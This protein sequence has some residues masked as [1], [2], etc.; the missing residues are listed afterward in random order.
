L[1]KSIIKVKLLLSLPCE[2]LYRLLK[3]T[4]MKHLH[5]Y[6]K[7]NF[8]LGFLL[9]FVFQINIKA[10][11]NFTTSSL[12]GA[13][14][15]NPTSLQFGPDNRLYVSQQNGIIKVFTVV[16]NSIN[17]YSVTATET[18]S[19]INQIPNHNDDGT[20]NTSVT[21]RQVTGILVTGT[22]SQPII[23]VTSSD[24]RIGGGSSG[25]DTNLD[26]N[27]G[28]LSILTWNGSTWVKMDLVRGLPRSEENHSPN[29]MQL[30]P[31]TNTLYMAVGGITNAGSPSN[32]FG[33]TCEY[34]L[35]AAILSI[36]L[37]AINAM[38]TKGSGNTAYKYDLPTVDDPTRTN[39]GSAD[40][41]DPFGGNDGLNQAKIV[42]G[43]PVKIFSPGYR[44][45]YDL[46]I[47]KTPGKVGRIYTI[48]NGAN[49]G[50]GGYPENEGTP[51]V[52]NN[53]VS[54]E[55]GSTGPSSTE[56]QVNNLD[57][58]H[59][60]GTLGSYIPGSYYGG[61]PVPIRANPSGA[62]LYTRTGT[63]GVFRTSTSGSNPLPSDW[64][65]VPSANPIEGDFQMP[66]TSA[67]NA[68]LT[69]TSST[70]GL[71][72]Y[73]AS[74]FN[75]ALK[76]CLLAAGY[77]GAIYKIS[78]TADGT[79]ATNSKSS[80]NKVNQD[81]P[82]ASGFGSTPLDV[83]AQG[84]ND[85]FPGTVWAATYGASAITI[86]EPADMGTC[87]GLYNSSDDDA[88]GYTNADEMDNGT[89]PCSA[90]SKPNDF[91]HDFISDLNDPDDD[92]DGIA[93]SVD[94]FPIDAN[95]GLTT[96][97]PI[98]YDLLN[99]Y[100][101]TGFFGV[102]FTGLMSNKQAGNNYLN[103]FDPNNL[104]AG[105]AVG[106]FT[107]VS[108]SAKDALGTLNNQENA[109]QFGVMAGGVPFTI[110][111]RMLGPFFSNQTPSGNQSQGI[112]I[113]TGDQSNYLKIT[114]NANNGQGG[115][116]VVN[117]NADVPVTTQFSIAGGIPS[118]TLD[119]YLSVNPATGTV[120]A[121]YASNGG[122]VINVGSPIQVN[123]ALLNALKSGGV[124]AIGIIS[125]SINATP[126]T[127]TW[128][129]IY[130]TKDAVT[131]TGSWQT[132]TPAA[133]TITTREENSYGQAGTKFYLMGGRG[134]V[135][136]QEYD[137]INKTW[138]NKAS[139][140]IELNHFQA[141]TLDGLIYA[142]CAFNGPF[143]HE[144]PVPQIYIYDPVG[145]K[146]LTGSTIPLARRR[147]S[148]GAVV[149]KNKIYL[150]GGITDGHWSGWVNWFDEYDPAT[151]TWRVLPNAPRP[152]DHFHIVVLND[153]LY[154]AG[155]R[156]SSDST[157]ELFS[158][159]IPEVDVY[160]F[161][162]GQWS[163]L[164]SASNIPTQRAG[165][166]NVII[167]NEVI[168]IGG[169]NTQP[170]A[171]NKTEALNTTTNTWRTLANL[172]QGRH[173]TQAIVNN[174]GIY[175]A[176]GAG[177]QGGSNLLSTQEAFYFSTP[178]TPTGQ[179]LSQSQLS[180]VSSLN[181]GSVPV[182]TTS[183]N[184]VTISN[185]G[186]NQAILVSS[187]SLTGSTA[188]SFISPYVLPFIIAPGKSVD[189]TVTFSP[190]STGSQ[191]GSL[192][193]THSGQGG[194][195]TTSLTG[196]GGSTTSNVVYRINSGG[197]QL[198]TSIGTFAADNYFSPSPGYTFS[199][200]TAIA[201]TTDDALYQTERSSTTDNGTFSYA[202]PVSNGTY[203]VVLHFAEIYQT[204]INKRVFDVSI[205]NVKVLDNYDIYKKVGGFTA[206]TETFTTTVSDGT[207]NINFSAKK[208]DGGIYRPEVTAIE[209]LNPGAN[210]SIVRISSFINGLQA[211]NYLSTIYPNPT[212]DGR[213]KVLLPREQEGEVVYSL[214]SVSGNVL[215]KGK[216]S[217]NR[218]TTVL[219]FNF[220][221]QMQNAGMYYLKLKKNENEIVFKLLRIN[222]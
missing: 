91:D 68:I 21:T 22:A 194:S 172:Q 164:S 147:G 111:A 203:T 9:F 71:A 208:K 176:A 210:P 103:N 197:P 143:P 179:A 110:K 117:E 167:G 3:N 75:N 201:G 50:W 59:Y 149:Y 118:S 161:I 74:N 181:F 16:R 81:P 41:N 215:T 127:A 23:Y 54:G 20:L 217:L 134:I 198:N 95:N 202:F 152:R 112:F 88:D 96:N 121:K 65:P 84:D 14:L 204:A 44:N 216:L 30:D 129:Y 133:G 69:F 15:T 200:T 113:G 170:T 78:L 92:N 46:V 58:L 168:V 159:T 145:N 32:N 141:V 85:I 45:A 132:L 70:N 26:T 218:P 53:Y 205:E 4:K 82:F 43:G 93:D 80:T 114:L 101:G 100:P 192:V 122:S 102:G 10:Q 89:N 162:T 76:G 52:T 55:P 62:G 119:L 105:G 5:L 86:F 175:I 79:D 104:V 184:K 73:T 120:Q 108:V 56:A 12:S 38:T 209:V 97:M 183:S 157:G 174:D 51:N 66:G 196:Q 130:V 67:S 61:H 115:I 186:S 214:M 177:N 31:S 136:V 146:W 154:V 98:N 155:G 25:T 72:E 173:G 6:C 57:G 2:S 19:I 190:S 34:A 148:A 180:A 128:D 8:I 27:S 11:V 63:T 189:I 171:S 221:Q 64:P 99:N 33:F 165:A 17:S 77:D 163:T 29:G 187:I 37:N 123:G 220:S 153:K 42:P 199:T 222:K 219:E 156:R 39:S 139:P 87:T 137:P 212:S 7:R 36:D 116:Q 135:P 94:V 140:P 166:S 48:D 144:V 40:V 131:N 83:I 13:V 124:V 207:L 142:V 193:V 24:S 191:S 18:I 211:N 138:S 49:Q 35:S 169:E 188:F 1:K 206:T 213:F 60:I 150:V 28:I 106:A 185:T 47:T 126:F 178:T 125:T 160:D 182:N 151:N 107:I 158:L 90:A 195:T 109:F